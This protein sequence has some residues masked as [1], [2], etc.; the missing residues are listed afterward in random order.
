M[1]CRTE[2]PQG[3]GSVPSAVRGPE[4][5]WIGHEDEPEIDHGLPPDA[6]LSVT[7]RGQIRTADIILV[8]GF[9]LLCSRGRP[10][11]VP[12][13]V[14]TNRNLEGVTHYDHNPTV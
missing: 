3:D 2:Y 12:K 6:V 14:V 13:I 11:R 10:V 4:L 8:P 1:G 5:C 9:D 7:Q